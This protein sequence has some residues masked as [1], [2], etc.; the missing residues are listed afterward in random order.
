MAIPFKRDLS[1]FLTS[2]FAG[3]ASLN[4]RNYNTHMAVV[5]T[6]QDASQLKYATGAITIDTISKDGATVAITPI[7]FVAKLSGAPDIRQSQTKS[8]DMGELEIINLDY[9]L[10]QAIT[11]VARVYDNAKI[12]VYWAFP[13]TSGNYEAIIY[14]DGL[15]QAIAGDDEIAKM[16]VI[17]DVSSKTSLVGAEITQRCLNE[18]GDSWCGV[19]NLPG[20]ATCSKV[21]RDTVNGCAYWGGVYQGLPQM[22]PDVA[23]PAGIWG[24]GTG[25]GNED[26]DSVYTGMN[27]PDLDTTIFPS[28]NGGIIHAKDLRVG[29]VILT[30]D[31]IP[32]TVDRCEVVDAPYRYLVKTI[33]NA[34]L[35]VSATHHFLR[36]P[37]DNKGRAAVNWN[38]AE[39]DLVVQLPNKNC[40]ARHTTDPKMGSEYGF[41]VAS[42]GKVLNLT[43]SKPHTYWAGMDEGCYL[44]NHN[45]NYDGINYPMWYTH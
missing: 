14:F 38:F 45:K 20:G 15:V 6:L 12:R 17:A 3:R 9:L 18:L 31:N 23:S 42:A 28:A 11:G 19:G 39:D 13:K 43:V 32:V 36:S 22:N 26:D 33:Y 40:L 27:C 24:S 2:F 25:T 41:M 10:T 35:I 1:P 37:D 16:S 8:P 4:S 34:D 30:G 5:I 44:G 7:T 29:E 21:W